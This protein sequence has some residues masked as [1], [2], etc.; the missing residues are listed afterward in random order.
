MGSL[1]S[2]ISLLRDFLKSEQITL[3]IRNIYI[4]GGSP[5][6]LRQYDFDI[7][8]NILGT[9]TALDGLN[10][11]TVEIDPRNTTKEM[12]NHYASI[13]VNS[14]S[15]GIQDFD[16]K[17]QKI[18]NRFQSP[19]MVESLLTAKL[20][21]LFKSINFDILVGLPGQ[22]VQSVTETINK[23]MN[24]SPERLSFTFLN[25][26]PDKYPNQSLMLKN[27]ELPDP[28]TKQ[29][30]FNAGLEIILQNGYERN[31]Y[32]HFSK[33]DDN[34]A[35]AKHLGKARYNSLGVTR[36]DTIGMIGLGRHSYSSVGD[37]YFQNFYEQ[38][39]YE[40]SLKC[41]I[42]PIYRGFHLSKDDKLRRN[43]IQALR[44]DFGINIAQISSEYDIDFF[45]YFKTELGCLADFVNDGLVKISGSRFEATET[46]IPYIL[47]ICRAFDKYVRGTR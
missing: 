17:V 3:D 14:I 6:L 9:I 32:E 45:N 40:A 4:G 28:Y 34:V 2:E 43:I 39:K 31:G 21:T 16:P 25:Y 10:S 44:T 30:I 11:F 13:G 46:G 5:T 18:V 7:L 27:A 1:Y 24:M 35:R 37:F 33:P 42:F 23:V 38:E 26:S 19:A 22:T 36:G 15:V 47:Q 12:L 29:Q 8:A 41:G 20:R